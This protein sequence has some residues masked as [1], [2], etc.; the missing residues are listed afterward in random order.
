M[1]VQTGQGSFICWAANPL[2]FPQNTGGLNFPNYHWQRSK[3]SAAAGLSQLLDVDLR[4]WWLC[5]EEMGW[6]SGK[7]KLISDNQWSCVHI[8]CVFVCQIFVVNWYLG[9][10]RIQGEMA[11]FEGLSVSW[12]TAHR[13]SYTRIIVSW[14]YNKMSH[15]CT[16]LHSIWCECML[17]KKTVLL[18]ECKHYVTLHITWYFKP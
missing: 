4:L 12:N 9:K 2:S 6:C 5:W 15:L 3:V 13:L 10:W 16:R 1:R 8:I 18:V 11:E 14:I 17:L 7:K